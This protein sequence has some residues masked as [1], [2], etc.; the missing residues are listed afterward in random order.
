MIVHFKSFV[1][2][3]MAVLALGI[4]SPEPACAA[5]TTAPGKT[6]CCTG[7]S[8]CKSHTVQPCKESCTLADSRTLDKQI[9]AKPLLTVSYGDVLLYL[10][11]PTRIKYPVFVAPDPQTDRQHLAA[12]WRQ[13]AAGDASPLAHLNPPSRLLVSPCLRAAGRFV[14]EPF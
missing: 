2:V 9:P 10:I 7:S 14:F 11:A 13:S 4:Y 12:I 3:L 6:C 1:Q 5:G 8:A